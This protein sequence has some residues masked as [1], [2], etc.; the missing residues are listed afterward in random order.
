MVNA[1]GFEPT[2]Y[3]LEG[4]CCYPTELRIHMDM[5]Y[6]FRPALVKRYDLNQTINAT[7]PTFRAMF[8]IKANLASFLLNFFM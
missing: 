1:V 5:V 2:T 4:R 3:A 6:L 8:I 7:V